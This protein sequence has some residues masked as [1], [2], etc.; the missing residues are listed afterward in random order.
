MH[1]IK[2]LSKANTAPIQTYQT[3]EDVR[4]FLMKAIHRICNPDTELKALG[5]LFSE[6]AAADQAGKDAME[7]KLDEQSLASLMTLAVQSHL[8]LVESVAS[9]YRSLVIEMAEQLIKEFNCETHSERA[10]AQ[11]A[12]VSYVRFM[13]LSKTL[14]QV[15]EIEFLQHATT[16]Y[17]GMIGREVDRAERRFRTTIM[18]L[19]QMKYPTMNL[20]LKVNTAFV[21]QNQQINASLEPNPEQP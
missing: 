2:N 9:R 14:N 16:G 8:P 10:I 4:K 13:A 18:T 17:Y 3:P 7:T 19:K 12:A 21:A 6:Y 1:K 5:K 20:Q 15:T 11:V